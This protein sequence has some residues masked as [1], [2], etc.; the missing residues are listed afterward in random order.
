M[1][2]S[3]VAALAAL[4]IIVA[5][6]GGA[7]V[8]THDSDKDDEDRDKITVT[9]AW[10][11]DIVEKITGDDFEVVSMMGANVNPHEAYSTPSNVSDM[12]QSKLYFKI[13]TGVEWETAFFDAVTENVPSSVKIVDISKNIEYEALP[14]QEHHHHSADEHSEHDYEHEESATDPHTRTSPE[15]LRKIASLITN[16]VSSINPDRSDVYRNNLDAYNKSVDKVDDRMKSVASVIGNGHAHVMVWHPAWQYLIQQYAS[17]F[18]T[19]MHMISVEAD[20]EVTPSEAVSIIKEE[21]CS[22]IF[23]STTD[24]GYEGRA[25]LEDAGIT[26]HVVSPTA[27]DMLES[28]TEFLNYLE[29]DFRS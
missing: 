1:N 14:N 17:K 9:M 6:I 11:K 8:L 16:E 13:G 2:N 24:E 23:V 25:S 12:Y 20:G 29:S 10:E 18:G 21:K 27:E 28:I 4:V 15:Y 7:L 5:A 19:D 3:L 26:V 22:S